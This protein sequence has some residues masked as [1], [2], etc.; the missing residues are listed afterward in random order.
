[1]QRTEE[2]DRGA[3]VLPTVAE[4]LGRPARTFEDWARA[5]AGAFAGRPGTA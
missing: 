5:H 4:L 3:E 2:S 1:M